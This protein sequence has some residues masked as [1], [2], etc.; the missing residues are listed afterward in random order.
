MVAKVVNRLGLH[1]RPAMTFVDAAMLFSSNITVA[2]GDTKVDGKS[3]MQMMM[4]AASQG[5]ELTIEAIG[6]DADKACEHLRQ[7]VAS[8]F[9]EE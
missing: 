9:D 2:K 7:L 8:G 6:E 4:L 5:S 3:I 1:A